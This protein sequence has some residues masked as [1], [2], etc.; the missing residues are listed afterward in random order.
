MLEREK[1]KVSISPRR[2]NIYALLNE[3]TFVSAP[4]LE[5]IHAS[6]VQL[7]VNAKR[8]HCVLVQ[9]CI[10]NVVSWRMFCL[11]TATLMSHTSIRLL[12]LDYNFII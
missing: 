6:S 12:H 4:L 11:P 2:S 1:A 10:D 8:N 7:R 9:I 5:Q 3:S